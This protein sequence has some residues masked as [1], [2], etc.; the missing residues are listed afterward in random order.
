MVKPD[1][2]LREL[3]AAIVAGD[4]TNVSRLLA[5]SPVLASACFQSGP[6]VKPRK[7]TTSIRLSDMSSRAT[8]GVERRPRPEVRRGC[9]K[10]QLTLLFLPSSAFHLVAVQPR[11][12][13]HLACRKA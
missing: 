11:S 4:A 7:H 10:P 13:F 9:G 2:A 6:L 3:V 8:G 12:E 5:A 1:L